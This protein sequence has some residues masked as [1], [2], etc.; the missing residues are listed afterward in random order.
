VQYGH[1]LNG[2]IVNKETTYLH[3]LLKLP[4]VAF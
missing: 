2:N 3:S 4:E 1:I